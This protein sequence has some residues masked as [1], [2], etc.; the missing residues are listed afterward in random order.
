MMQIDTL[1]SGL[2]SQ[3][4]ILPSICACSLQTVCLRLLQPLGSY[5][6]IQDTYAASNSH[7]S[8]KEPSWAVH[9][10]QQGWLQCPA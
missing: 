8:F 9:G 6:C 7:E 4:Q 5:L 1:A 3:M 2:I 10:V